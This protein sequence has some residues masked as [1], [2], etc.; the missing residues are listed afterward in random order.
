MTRSS[1]AQSAQS[2]DKVAVFKGLTA[3]TLAR[4]QKR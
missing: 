1:P 2:L 4:I 3:D